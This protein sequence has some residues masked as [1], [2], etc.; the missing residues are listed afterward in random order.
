MLVSCAPSGEIGTTMGYGISW[1]VFQAYY[2]E[3][4]FNGVD[5]PLVQG[6]ILSLIG[7][8]MSFVSNAYHQA[9]SNQFTLIYQKVLRE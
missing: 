8:L 7:S 2:S 5:K 9:Y 6:T 3:S 4:V 1:G